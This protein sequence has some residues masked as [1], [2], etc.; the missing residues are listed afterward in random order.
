MALKRIVQ[1]I[2][3]TYPIVYIFFSSNE[4]LHLSAPA[5]A[6]LANLPTAEFTRALGGGEVK[7][8]VKSK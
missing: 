4:A 3:S 1:H 5:P 7:W 8:G 2:F 6:P